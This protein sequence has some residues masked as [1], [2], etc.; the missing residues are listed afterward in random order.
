MMKRNHSKTKQHKKN[1]C[2]EKNANTRNGVRTH[3]CIC[4]LDL[5]SNTL[6]TRPPWRDSESEHII[7]ICRYAGKQL[8]CATTALQWCNQKKIFNWGKGYKQETLLRGCTLLEWLHAKYEAFCYLGGLG[9]CSPR[10]FWTMHL[11]RL[12]LVAISTE[13]CKKLLPW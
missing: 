11:L 5:K 7:F 12:N 9:A 4:T 3:V 1:S 6:T 8:C 2:V 10:N 13:I